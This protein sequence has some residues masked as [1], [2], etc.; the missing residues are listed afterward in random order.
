MTGGP[1]VLEGPILSCTEVDLGSGRG[2]PG[3]SWA[4]EDITEVPKELSP[5]NEQ[6]LAGPHERELITPGV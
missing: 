5:E 4:H 6:H 2:Y 1:Q 3:Q